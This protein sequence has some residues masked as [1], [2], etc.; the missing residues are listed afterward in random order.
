MATGSGSNDI[1]KYS[2]KIV[3]LLATALCGW[4][5]EAGAMEI[6]LHGTHTFYGPCL[7]AFEKSTMEN[8]SCHNL[9]FLLI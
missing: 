1:S 4:L 2:L 8:K 3:E 9:K 7:A 5:M 6:L